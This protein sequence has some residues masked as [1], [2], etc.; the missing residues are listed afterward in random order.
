MKDDMAFLAKKPSETCA[1]IVPRD[2]PQISHDWVGVR[3]SQPF[4]ALTLPTPEV[5]PD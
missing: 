2:L 4:L 1:V 5:L 3:G